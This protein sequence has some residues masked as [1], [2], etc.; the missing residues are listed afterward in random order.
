MGQ[1]PEK[2]GKEANCGGA[3]LPGSRERERGMNEYLS[4]YSTTLPFSG[5]FPT[6]RNENALW[7]YPLGDLPPDPPVPPTVTLR[8]SDIPRVFAGN[9]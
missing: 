5:D 3:F 8:G 1:D 9:G 4:L 2:G 6:V 7:I